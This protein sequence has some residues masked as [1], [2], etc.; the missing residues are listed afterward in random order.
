MCESLQQARPRRP[1]ALAAFAAS[2]VAA[3]YEA[4]AAE[5]H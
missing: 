3:R 5:A 4:L 1:D 2:S